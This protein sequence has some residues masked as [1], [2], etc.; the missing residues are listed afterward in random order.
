MNKKLIFA[1]EGN[2]ELANKLANQLNAERGHFEQ[3]QFPDKETYL[4][5]LSE[6]QGKKAIVICTLNDP[7]QK[8][9]PL[10]F[11]AKALKD[12]G[13]SHIT[14]VAPYLGYMR[15]DKIFKEGEALTSVVFARVL[16]AFVDRI[17]TVDPH[18]H[19]RKNM[20]EIYSVPCAVL[21]AAP[22]ISRYIK[23]TIA[24]PLVIGP[25][26]ESEQWVS[27]VAQG[28]NAPFVV[29]EKTRKGDRDVQVSVPEVEKY[30]DYTPVLVDDIVSTARTMIETVTH[31]TK[32]KMRKPVCIATHGVFSG[33]AYEDLLHTGA[34]NVATCN[35]IV[36]HSNRIDIS[37]IIA[38]SLLI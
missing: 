20:E 26:S 8:L 29:L 6:V 12:H 36:H 11:L 5:V 7:D 17:I 34:S 19:R 37:G 24:R 35:T 14:L 38:Q 31:L 15:Q 33:S 30:R 27:E 16:S 9:L 4:R 32:T 28:A 3:R 10:L 22:L 13:A 2:E 18:L 23:E 1:L 25:D 21:H